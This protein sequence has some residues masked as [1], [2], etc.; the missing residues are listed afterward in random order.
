MED[1]DQLINDCK[2]GKREAQSRLY[3]QYAPKLFGVC[4]RYSRDETEAEDTLHEAFI[5]IFNKI[6]Q[7]AFKGSFEGWMKRIV[8]NIS[9]EKCRSRYKMNTVEDISIYESA[10]INEDVYAELNAGQLLAMI[11]DLSPRY[12]MVFN[13]YAIDGYMH[14]EI[15]EML[16]ISE[17]T[18]KSDLARARKILQDKIIEFGYIGK[19]Y[20]E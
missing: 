1:L 11:R 19:E 20:A 17:G 14:K 10:S 4:L 2:A 3:S 5:T 12:R 8:V 18:S 13:L 7:F 6:G 15:A 9:L 16:N